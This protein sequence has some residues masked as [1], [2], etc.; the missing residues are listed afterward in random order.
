[1]LAQ[2]HKVYGC[3]HC[4]DHSRCEEAVQEAILRTLEGKR[5]IQW[6]F[7]DDTNDTD[8]ICKALYC[9]LCWTLKSLIEQKAR[10][11]K[12]HVSLDSTERDEDSALDS[13]LSK[14][15]G[16]HDTPENH[17]RIIEIK[18]FILSLVRTTANKLRGT[19]AETLIAK[20]DLTPKAIAD[21]LGTDVKEVQNARRWLQRQRARLHF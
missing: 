9:H 14:V 11:E 21:E 12:N 1:M 10:Q 16:S 19:I 3:L 7:S 13:L 2:I 6:Q 15:S 8:K 17:V 5:L 18:G 4:G 20:P